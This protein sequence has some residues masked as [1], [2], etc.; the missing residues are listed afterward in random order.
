M[1]NKRFLLIIFILLLPFGASEA[2]GPSGASVYVASSVPLSG[3]MSVVG[4]SIKQAITAYYKQMNIAGGL[5][6][7]TVQLLINNDDNEPSQARDNFMTFVKNDSV[8]AVLSPW[9]TDAAQLTAPLANDYKIPLVGPITGASFI[10]KSVPDEY[11]FNF[12]ASTEHELDTLL[13][14]IFSQGITIENVAFLIEDDIYGSDG[15]QRAMSL[16]QAKQFT[17]AQLKSI[18]VG[19]YSRN[20]SNVD[21]AIKTIRAS[22]KDIKAIVMLASFNQAAMFIQQAKQVYPDAIF[23]ATS[24]VASVSL[25]DTLCQK[26]ATLCK[27]YCRNVVISQVVPDFSG[28]VPIANAYK[29]D[30][31]LFF[32][33]AKLTY[34]GFEAYINANILHE[35]LKK[36]L[37][38]LSRESVNDAFLKLQNT[39]IG[40]GF[41]ITFTPKIHQASQQVWMTQLSEG[42]VIPYQFPHVSD[43]RGKS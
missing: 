16:L 12:R 38:P 14:G 39:D 3:E 36:A 8:I 30:M 20:G 27:E 32:P 26:N 41:P 4:E 25:A 22:Q 2:S 24:S 18:P 21:D 43:Q 29:R 31:K 28:N 37:P 19:R 1:F 9:G 34:I 33:D 10:H 42:Q 7:T 5:K 13:T 11:V 35:A 6:G 23:A 17:D 40:I 15:Y